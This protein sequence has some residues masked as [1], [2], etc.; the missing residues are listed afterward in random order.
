M[1]ESPSQKRLLSL[2]REFESH[3]CCLSDC[4]SDCLSDYTPIKFS[5]SIIK[6]LAYNHIEYNH[7]DNISGIRTR[8][9]KI[10]SVF[11]IEFRSEKDMSENGVR[12]Q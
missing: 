4:R 3:R 2:Q 5:G 6:T 12:T 7:L 9:I 1:M 10:V 11:E 8:A